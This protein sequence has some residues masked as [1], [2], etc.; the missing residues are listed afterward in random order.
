MK[1]L[2]TLVL[3]CS[4]LS[5]LAQS[6]HTVTSSADSGAG[7]L[8]EAV[9]N[10]SSG[11]IIVFEVAQ[12]DLSSAITVSMPYIVGDNNG[13]NVTINATG[14]HRIFDVNANLTLR[15]LTLTGGSAQDGGAV[16]V[17]SGTFTAEGVT[18]SSNSASRNGGALFVASGAAAVI[19]KCAFTSNSVS[20][21]NGDSGGAISA[22]GNLTVHQ[23][24]FHENTAASAGV[25]HAKGGAVA[26]FST[27]TLTRS[28][29]FENT[30]DHS[31][32][33][34][35]GA[36]G[37]ALYIGGSATVHAC[38]VA[39]NSCVIAG[40]ASSPPVQGGGIYTAGTLQLRS[41][42]VQHNSLA[43]TNAATKNGPHL[44][45]SGSYTGCDYNLIPNLAGSGYSQATNDITSGPVELGNLNTHDGGAL[46]SLRP[47]C[48]SASLDAGDPALSFSDFNGTSVTNG[49]RDIGAVESSNCDGGCTNQ[50]A[51]NYDAS[52]EFNDDSC[53]FPEPY[54]D[55]DGCINDSDNDG[56]CDELE[57][58]GCSN[59]NACN[60]NPEATEDANCITT[61]S[62]PEAQEIITDCGG[63]CN[64]SIEVAGLGEISPA[65]SNYC[66]M[67]GGNLQHI[68]YVRVHGSKGFTKNSGTGN[69]SDFTDISATLE[70]AQ[71]FQVTMKG[72]RMSSTG[73]ATN[74]DG[75]LAIDWN[76]DGVFQSSERYSMSASYNGDNT[77]TYTK[78][79]T[80]P[81]GM[82]GVATR[83]RVMLLFE[84]STGAIVCGNYASGET[85][86]YTLIIGSEENYSWS[87]GVSGHNATSIQ[88]LC[89]GTYTLTYTSPL[90]CTESF[91]YEV[92]GSADANIISELVPNNQESCTDVS[93]TWNLSVE[94]DPDATVEYGNYDET[95]LGAGTF[96]A[97]ITDSNGCS[98][99]ESVTIDATDILR[100]GCTDPEA[101]NYAE[102]AECDD[103]T[104]EYKDYNPQEVLICDEGDCTG[105]IGIIYENFETDLPAA[106]SPN[107]NPNWQQSISNVQTRVQLGGINHQGTAPYGSSHTLINQTG[108]LEIG[109]TYT[110]TLK[111]WAQYYGPTTWAGVRVWIDWNGDGNFSNAERVFN[112]GV[113]YLSYGNSAG[114]GSA[115]VNNVQITVPERRPGA[116]RMRV[117]FHGDFF[118]HLANNPCP[119]QYYS[120]GGGGCS[121]RGYSYDYTLNI[122]PQN[123]GVYWSNDA[124]GD[125]VNNLCSGAYT[126]TITDVTGCAQSYDTV[127]G[128][129]T[130]YTV[131]ATA[132]DCATGGLTLDIQ[133]ESASAELTYD[134]PAV[135]QNGDEIT[136]NFS[137]AGCANDI[138]V[139]HTVSTD[140][141]CGCTDQ[142]ACNYTAEATDDDGSCTYPETYY[143]C[144]NNCLN[145]AD[146][147]GVC[148]ELE[149]DGCT[150]ADACNYAAEA[151][152]DD[153]SCTYP[154]AA[155][156]NCAGQCINDTDQDG[157]CDEIEVAGCTDSAACNYNAQ[158]TDDN[159]SCTYAQTHYNCAGD[160]LNDADNDGVCD[161]LE[162]AGCTDSAACNY[163]AE[164]TDED[165]SCFYAETY[166]DCAG[167][168]L[169]DA[170]N[171]GVCD[172]LEVEGCTDSA[173]C[174]Y[175]AEATDEDGSCFYAETHYDCAGDCLNDSDGDG[176]CD[177]I[178]VA[179]CTD[180]AACNYNAQATDEDNSCTYAESE[181]DC[182]GV[183][184]NDADNDGVCD[185][186]EVAGC[187]DA[188]ACNFNPEATDNDG[189]CTYPAADYLDCNGQ[190]LSDSDQDGVCDELEIAGCTDEGACNYVAEATDDDGS[191]FFAE[192]YYDCAGACLSDSDN[193]GVC[194][195]LEVAGCTDESACN[196]VAE[197]TD[198][199]GSCFYPEAEILDCE[200]NCLNDADGDGICDELEIPGCTDAL[201]CN[202]NPEATDDDGLCYTV[203]EGASCDCANALDFG[204]TFLGTEGDT[205]NFQANGTLSFVNVNLAW[206]NLNNDWSWASDLVVVITSPSGEC[207]QWGGYD[208]FG[209]EECT[210]LGDYTT[211][212]TEW[213][214]EV[215][216]LFEA[217]TSMGETNLSGE[218]E[219][220]LVIMSGYED[221][222]GVSYDLSFEFV[223][224]CDVHVPGCMNPDACN[225]NAWA[226]EDDGSC[227]VYPEWIDCSGECFNDCDGD[228]ICDE[229][230]VYGCADE[231][232]CNYNAA[233][234]EP[235]DICEYAA[236]FYDCNNSCLNDADNDGVCDELEISGCTDDTA[237]NF[238]AEATDDDNSCSYAA[239]GF[240]CEG[241]Q[242]ELPSEEVKWLLPQSGSS[243]EGEIIVAFYLDEPTAGDMAALTF[244]AGISTT[245]MISVSPGENI[246]SINPLDLSEVANNVLGNN[247]LSAGTYDLH[248]SYMS[249]GANS[250]HE[251]V[252]ESVTITPLYAGCTYAD[253]L[254][255]APDANKD[256]GSCVFESGPSPCG[257]G[258]YYDASLGLCLPLDMQTCVGDLNADAMISVNDLLILLGEFGNTCE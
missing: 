126:Y 67:S 54:Y 144:Q 180:E 239:Y 88:N 205:L 222:E 133:N 170:D 155:Y 141:L 250:A 181:Y 138:A 12:I 59:P 152:N 167:N 192:T 231:N 75:A 113:Q 72:T 86:D 232:A 69:Y 125:E 95:N 187:D 243:V 120:C 145:D 8:R 70:P 26:A 116:V 171:D 52:A 228:G 4:T 115:T 257:D 150:D 166:Y 165:G 238:V 175:V 177:E 221:S 227:I 172:E 143:D 35:A 118:N 173:A 31:A 122:R 19:S 236:E 32:N 207:V 168:C 104:C 230:E 151:T 253:A 191:C 21:T 60:Y 184:L 51:C 130:D 240:D 142:N 254:N 127:L 213:E 47:A 198:E 255:Y 176:V 11:D 129:E 90:G 188:D 78:T 61:A 108:E 34:F 210:S 30:A 91:D 39:S 64:G 106:P 219:W 20:G 14:N 179:G 5:L 252:R 48:P 256:D 96:T 174:N 206:D 102:W 161:E 185:A 2:L 137:S 242:I 119:P 147:D 55:C 215:S 114:E 149:I 50:N 160:C 258:T 44:A 81:S 46:Q 10:A 57:I 16:N 244:A 28:I 105:A 33:S 135:V 193:D 131:E 98:Y 223:G 157:V 241:N 159:S 37:G 224:L 211:W 77:W 178:E 42:I 22:Q 225:Y 146:N 235:I 110:M 83:M 234:T 65:P 23:S 163:V 233:V 103:G 226:V 186:F 29:F 101:C 251:S 128:V 80:V 97:T 58:F 121:S 76:R 41:S 139:T 154:D 111:R 24:L 195:E 68:Y 63:G 6:T 18:F 136:L 38:T 100:T 197:A 190:C 94:G 153:G 208:W 169:N 17:Q 74:H 7:T 158:A 117:H 84:Q 71:T 43:H 99:T 217:T 3:L 194:D 112:T 182:D 93:Y 25:S 13:D 245:V 87:T 1:Q 247:V 216:G 162:V 148:D 214:T 62:A 79:I 212:P 82:Y 9:N 27:L 56:V 164:A 36:R 189:S 49:Q 15:N 85:E 204:G 45:S 196:F 134:L 66:A 200:G 220:S 140:L 229:D 202:Y 132:I 53:L 201:A 248:L 183:C 246:V 218:G 249:V 156:L 123:Q 89:A 124:T 109:K 92:P 209:P 40:G 107:C 199:D 237:C 73:G 203:P